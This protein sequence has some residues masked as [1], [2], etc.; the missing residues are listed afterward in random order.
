VGLYLND[1]K[2]TKILSTFTLKS[3]DVDGVG[4]EVV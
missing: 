1:V 2:K 4:V 3:F